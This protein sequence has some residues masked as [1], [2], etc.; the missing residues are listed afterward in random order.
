MPQLLLELTI[1][2]SERSILLTTRQRKYNLMVKHSFHVSWTMA[3]PGEGLGR[4]EP[5]WKI[6]K[7]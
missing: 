6:Q 7:L 2:A 5:P 1:L 3:E 4:L